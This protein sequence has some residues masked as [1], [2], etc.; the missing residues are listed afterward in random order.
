MKRKISNAHG[1]F[2]NHQL[3][4]RRPGKIKAQK[5]VMGNPIFK[6]A[7]SKIPGFPLVKSES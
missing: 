5:F 7:E 6:L 4:I 2:V 3:F 1:L